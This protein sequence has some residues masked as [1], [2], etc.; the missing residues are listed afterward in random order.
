MTAPDAGRVPAR[1]R[2]HA[3]RQRPRSSAT[4]SDTCAARVRTSGPS[5]Q[6]ATGRSSR[7]CAR[8]SATRTISAP[9]SATGPR[10]RATRS[11]L[12][13]VLVPGGLSV[14][15]PAVSRAR[16]TVIEHLRTW[17]PTVILSD[18]D[19]VFQPRKVQRSGLWDGGRGPRADL[20]PQGAEAGRRREA[21]PGPSLRHGGRQAA[22]PG[23]G[24]EESGAPA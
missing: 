11:F 22:H 10:T 6:T 19:V 24:E 3:A 14:R 7:S 5:A 20:H 17:G 8:S 1:R 9:C 15:R 13:D 21:L 4:C 12:R 23:G 18:G 2:Q 16:S